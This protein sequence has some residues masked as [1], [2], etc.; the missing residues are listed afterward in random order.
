[1]N[2]SSPF[3]PVEDARPAD[4]A[5]PAM[6]W[7]STLGPPRAARHA[8]RSVTGPRLAGRVVEVLPA[9]PDRDA[10]DLFRALDDDRVWEHVAGRPA[11]A[12][13][14]SRLLADRIAAGVV[15]WVVRLLVPVAGL[16]PGT[17]AGTS[18]YLDVAVDDARLEIGSTAYRPLL[19]GGAVNPD[20]KRL[21]LAYAFEVLGAGRV[22]LKTDVRNRRSQLAIAGLGARYEGTLRRYQR[23]QDGSVRDTVLF[24]ILAEEWPSVRD[25]LDRRLAAAGHPGGNANT[26]HG[27]G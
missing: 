11:S 17:V 7:P 9:D 3:R 2:G 23:R 13:A 4:T 27:Q 6:S 19:W 18:A 12:A 10:A 5:W 26:P 1:M 15:P 21:L 20:T 16:P 22:Q 14:W 8:D 24:S 25:R